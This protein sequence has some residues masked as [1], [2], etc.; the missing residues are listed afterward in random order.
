M[1][2]SP[3]TAA[4]E[5]L[6]IE[7]SGWKQVLPG[8]GCALSVALCVWLIHPAL[9]MGTNDDWSY[10]KTAQMFATTGHFVYN[11][12]ATAMLGW[13][14]PWGALFIK[15]F[16]FSFFAVRMST[17][18]LA[19]ASAYLFYVILL[20]FGI[21]V[22]NAAFGTLVFALSPLSL[23]LTTSFMTDIPSVFAI[24]VC[25][26]CCL[27]VLSTKNDRSAL[28]WLCLAAGSN[29]LLGTVRQIV[30]LGVLVMVPSTVWLV[31]RRRNLVV[32]GFLLWVVS[33]ISIFLCM[34]WFAHQPYI[35]P[36]KLIPGTINSR[37]VGR[38]CFQMFRFALSILLFSFPILVAWL[39]AARNLRRAARIK[40][41]TVLLLYI[42]ILIWGQK[43]GVLDHLVP[44]WLD[45][46][47]TEKGISQFPAILGNQPDVLPLWLR[48]V[49]GFAVITVALVAMAVIT[50]EPRKD[51]TPAGSLVW[52]TALI[53]LLPFA[54]ANCALLLP[55]SLA[56]D[57]FDR[58]LLPVMIPALI[59]LLLAYEQRFGN[60]LPA[61]PY[62]TLALF[63][64]FAVAGT[65]DEFAI[66]RARLQAVQEVLAAGVPRTAVS[67]GI[68]YDGWTQIETQGYLND[69]RLINPPGAYHAP[70]HTIKDCRRRN[71]FFV[72]YTPAVVPEYVVVYTPMP[73][74]EPSWFAPVP[75]Q[76]WM[77]P[78]HRVMYIQQ[79]ARSTDNNESSD[80]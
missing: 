58:Y 51:S 59:L 71:S 28:L 79:E 2:Q 20:R 14:I 31:R 8:I 3:A 56:F 73:C 19:M 67:G 47:V 15:L 69:P 10:I 80:Q 68:E 77:A 40:I 27:R 32:A 41:G 26:Y 23:P 21:S 72:D 48:L 36:E 9:E 22:Q 30:W 16:G 75:Y 70:V 60:R 39:T 35:L 24:L 74:L 66:S 65:H 18:P 25:L 78:S 52:R 12:W 4:S 49:I 38:S 29:V 34:R 1:S 54:L 62:V 64:C 61:V 53:L 46:L 17:L 45:N 7:S 6:K 33:G 57:L 5:D 43:R 63:T 76:T 50:S 37:A 55:R 11:A 42:P 44:P 13:Q